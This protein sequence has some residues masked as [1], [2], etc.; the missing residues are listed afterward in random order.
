MTAIIR[1]T[2]DQS[3]NRDLLKTGTLR[4]LFDNTLSKAKVE[5]PNLCN[6][7]TDSDDYVRDMR[8]ASLGPAVDVTQGQNVPI[9]QPVY[10]ST[11]EYTQRSF[12]TGFRMT[13]RMEH[14][15]KYKLWAKWSGQLAEVMKKSK[16]IEIATMFNNLTSATSTFGVGFD[17]LEIASTAH[18]GLLAGSTT[19]NYDNYLNAD[20]SVTAVQNGR[21][22]FETLKDDLGLW[23]GAKADT[24][25]YEPTFH[26][27]AKEITGSDYKPHEF[28]NTINVIPEMDLKLFEYHR[29]TS[30]TCWGLAAKNDPQY[31]INVITTMEPQFFEKDAPDNT[32][33][34]IALSYQY[35]TYGFGDPRLLCVGRT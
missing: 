5:Y 2:F 17:G 35:F 25:W 16:D 19:D 8:I 28:S 18:T 24:L 21:Y 23:M 30:T 9:Q 12:A 26:F 1:T 32:L 3:T 4:N 10:G 13:H 29:L 34:K 22:Y 31:D 20:M 27:K 15:N 14:F 6:D 33:D 7:I 11:K